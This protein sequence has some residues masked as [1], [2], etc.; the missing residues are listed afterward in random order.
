MAATRVT[1]RFALGLV[2]LLL[3]LGLALVAPALSSADHKPV[4]V[5]FQ[6]HE[7][8]SPA[9]SNSGLYSLLTSSCLGSG[10]DKSYPYGGVVSPMPLPQPSGTYNGDALFGDQVVGLFPLGIERRG[11]Q[12]DN[13]FI[14][15][16]VNTRAS[17][18]V[19]FSAEGVSV[20]GPK[21]KLTPVQ[22]IVQVNPGQT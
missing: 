1:G 22:T 9:F 16:G 14:L 18:T 4:Q 13:H 12:N 5:R 2:G 21:A 10:K 20:C 11:A 8:T 3:A 17:F 6:V 19:S 15:N 7:T